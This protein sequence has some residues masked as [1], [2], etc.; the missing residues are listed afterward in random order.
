MTNDVT[1]KET[2][3]ESERNMHD[4]D[5]L[6]LSAMLYSEKTTFPGSIRQQEEHLPYYVHQNQLDVKNENGS[7]LQSDIMGISLL[8]CFGKV[9]A[10]LGY[11]PLNQI[12]VPASICHR[13]KFKLEK[14]KTKTVIDTNFY[15]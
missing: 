12:R 4:C 1:E 14:N 2:Y 11:Y 9:I 7:I 5:G 13:R 6:F 15:S 8:K 3:T 10:H